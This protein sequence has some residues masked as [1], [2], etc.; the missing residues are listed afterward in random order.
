MKSHHCSYRHAL[1]LAL[2]FAF[3]CSFSPRAQAAAFTAD[4]DLFA[5]DRVIQIE[6]T[7]DP[8]GWHA[9]R[10]SHRDRGDDKSVF[11]F[12]EKPYKYYRADVVIEGR[13]VGSV[14]IR[15]KGFVGSAIST[16]PSLK[17]K[18]SEYIDDQAFAGLDM[19]T[20]NNNNQDPSQAQQLMAY[21]LMNQAGVMAPRCNLARIRVNGE[22]LGAYTHVESIRKPFIKRFFGKSKGDLYEGYA[23]DFKTNEINR[24]VHKWGKDDDLEELS[25]LLDV[26]NT[27]GPIDLDEIER[28]VDLDGFIKLWAAE[29]LVGHEDS[30]SGNRNNWYVFRDRETGRF[31]FIVWGTDSNFRVHRRYTGLTVPKSVRAR[32]ELCRRLWELPEIRIRY[33]SEMQQMLN[34]VWDEEKLLAQL[35]HAL[36]MTQPYRT[37]EEETVVAIVDRIRLYITNRRDEVQAELN[38]S[39]PDWPAPRAATIVSEDAPEMNVTGTFSTVM[40][41]SLERSLSDAEKAYTT[42]EAQIEFTID[43]EA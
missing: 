16:R 3:V 20:F 38:G 33:Q 1:V 17:I 6:V 15:K 8:D 18:F 28:M 40:G 14:G 9:L 22:D 13:R 25:K 42:G 26:I 41:G 34:S 12:A 11:K 7:M 19:M 4:D 2:A 27:P 39:M 37:V 35:D 21:S 10:I 24:I 36:E 32:G 30:Y 31:H 23:G 43:G 5:L 29:V